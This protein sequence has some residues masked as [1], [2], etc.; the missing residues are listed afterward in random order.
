MRIDKLQAD[1]LTVNVF[2]CALAP[3]FA[4]TPQ[5]FTAWPGSGQ[6]ELGDPYFTML[7][8][9]CCLIFAS[10][11]ATPP[12]INDALTPSS[13]RQEATSFFMPLRICVFVTFRLRREANIS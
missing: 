12:F 2:K 8:P 7:P 6:T 11:A 9:G 1:E 5:I 13:E 3:Q 10:S 4:I